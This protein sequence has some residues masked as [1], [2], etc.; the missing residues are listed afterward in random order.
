MQVRSNIIIEPERSRL[1]LITLLI[2]YHARLSTVS[3]RSV[4]V[5]RLSWLDREVPSYRIAY[6]IATVCQILTDFRIVGQVRE[7]VRDCIVSAGH[8]RHQCSDAPAR[9]AGRA[10][11]ARYVQDALSPARH[12]RSLRVVVPGTPYMERH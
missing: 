11:T 12:G 2:P 8:C 10:P 6:C 3:L 5:S 4:R 7:S 9:T 1:K